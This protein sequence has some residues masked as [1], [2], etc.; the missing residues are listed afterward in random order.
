L[1]LF[2]LLK[3]VELSFTRKYI[4]SIQNQRPFTMSNNNESARWVKNGNVHTNDDFKFKVQNVYLNIILLFLFF[5][6]FIP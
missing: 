3:F 6:F 4:I 1:F 2:K 5:F